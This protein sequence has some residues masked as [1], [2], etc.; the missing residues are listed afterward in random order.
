VIKQIGG[1]LKNEA[2][3]TAST[4]GKLEPLV[5]VSPDKTSPE[6][7]IEVIARATRPLEYYVD[8]DGKTLKRTIAHC[9]CAFL[10]EELEVLFTRNSQDIVSILNQCFDAGDLNYDLKNKKSSYAKNICANIIAGTYPEAVNDLFNDKVISAGFI[11]R[12]I[13]VYAS[14]PRFDRLFPGI[15]PDQQ[16]AFNEIVAHVKWLA[17]KVVGEVKLSEEAYEYVKQIYESGDLRKRLRVNHDARLDNYYG[18]KRIHWLK[19]GM[20]MHFSEPTDT[21]TISK[22]TM[23]S[24]FELLNR[25]EVRMHEGFRSA[26]R[27]ELHEIG[28][29]MMKYIGEKGEVRHKTLWFKFSSELRRVEFDEC[30]DMLIGT[31]QIINTNRETSMLSSGTFKLSSRQL[32]TNGN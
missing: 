9:S 28:N 22:S 31:T 16:I 27:N 13:M 24:A 18:R 1:V 14:E 19:L 23:E 29:Q 11:S 32:S 8:I 15:N 17:T 10:I 3:Y 26:G 20:A 12:I 6:Q 21:Y 25:T 2:M 30:L 5:T 7:L 4:S